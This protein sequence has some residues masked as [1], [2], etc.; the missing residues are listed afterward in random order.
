MALEGNE[1]RKHIADCQKSALSQKIY[2]EKH[3]LNYNTFKYWKCK[4]NKTSQGNARA[5]FIEIPLKKS[6]P[7]QE[8]TITLSNGI[9][10][11]TNADIN[12]ENISILISVLKELE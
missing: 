2:C 3:K 5:G 12:P 8:I 11:T 9:Q 7:N 1:W 10:V 4:L 6:L